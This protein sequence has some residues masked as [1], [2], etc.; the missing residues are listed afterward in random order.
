M[1]MNRIEP[2]PDNG[3]FPWVVR[4]GKNNCLWFAYPTLIQA[5]LKFPKLVWG[6]RSIG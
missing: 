3:S 5:I 2:H 6:C 1:G 4:V